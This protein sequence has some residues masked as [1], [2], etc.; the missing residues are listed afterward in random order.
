MS[1]MWQWSTGVLLVVVVME[2][3]SP[4]H[5][6]GHRGGADTLSDR[7]WGKYAASASP[8]ALRLWGLS[9]ACDTRS[10]ALDQETQAIAPERW[11][12]ELVDRYDKLYAEVERDRRGVFK[13]SLDLV[14]T[15]NDHLPSG[16]FIDLSSPMCDRLVGLLGLYFPDDFQEK[17][18]GGIY[19]TEPYRPDRDLILM[20]HG[21]TGCPRDFEMV[22]PTVDRSR[23]QVWVAYYPTGRKIPDLA[24]F[25]RRM[26]AT[27]LEK[28]PVRQI[29]V[30]CHSL[31]G[32]V[33]RTIFAGPDG[34]PGKLAA[35]YTICTPHRGV[36]F[37]LMGVVRIACRWLWGVVPDPVLDLLEGSEFLRWL[38]SQPA[39]ATP[40]R[41]VAGNKWKTPEAQWVGSLI[42]VESDGLVPV[43]NASAP[44]C[45]SHEVLPEDHYSMKPA[46]EFLERF[47]R[48]L[49]TDIP[50]N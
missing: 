21:F 12:E 46:R 47:A 24:K 25:I 1:S 15:H 2:T 11:T 44:G 23:F 8:V 50:R 37:F 40:I 9:V 36:K 19:L 41:S 42:P 5:A 49:S 31:G 48:W 32:L 6:V 7:L 10:A 20:V 3:C 17:I 4:V 14:V 30:C 33:M 35:F 22:I 16:S 29:V 28:H 43:P 45:L 38:N 26:L 27:E 39:P 34:F 13:Q 18:G